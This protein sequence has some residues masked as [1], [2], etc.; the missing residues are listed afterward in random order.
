MAGS[1]DPEKIAQAL[2]SGN[3]ECDTAWGHVRIDTSGNGDLTYQLV[4]IGE[5]GKLTKVW[6]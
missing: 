4:Y 3:L 1:D 5:G 6:P 2:R